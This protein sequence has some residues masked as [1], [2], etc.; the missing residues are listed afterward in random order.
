MRT[1]AAL[2]L[3]VLLAA[4]G[5]GVFWM[6]S[7]NYTTTQ[8]K[9]TV[10]QAMNAQVNY[11]QPQ[12]VPDAMQV[13]MELPSVRMVMNAGPVREIAA[14]R[15]KLSSPFFNR[16][17]WTMALPPRVDVTLAQGQ[18]M[19]LETHDGQ[20][21]W[22]KDG[23]NLTLKADKVRLLSM[24]G[25][26][27]AELGDLVLE[28]GTSGG[29]I[30]LNLASRP[31]WP[32]GEAVVSGKVIVPP[33]AFG[34]MVNMFGQ[35]RMPG[36]ASLMQAAS[37]ALKPGDAVRIESLSFRHQTGNKQVSGGM[38]GDMRVTNDRRLSGNLTLTSDKVETLKAWISAAGLVAPRTPG[39]E[40][41]ETR[42]ERGLSAVGTVRMA[43]MQSTLTL[44]GQPVGPLPRVDTV[45][46]R[47][48]GR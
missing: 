1:L 44:N 18:K 40:V 25:T 32:G 5:Y 34:A 48:W 20:I 41:G 30:E 39:E 22:M 2:F 7:L 36:V 46:N 33:A 17:R 38:F 47:L 8:M 43:H 19:I 29:A 42:F 9:G 4:L 13:T 31:K 15:L 28:R 24:D 26:E 16:D 6:V 27:L 14:P 21:M 35:G 12:W 3:S 11:G 23:N 10:E 45:T 37:A